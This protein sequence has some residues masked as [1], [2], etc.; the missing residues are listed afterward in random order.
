MFSVIIKTE[1]GTR[2]NHYVRMHPGPGMAAS[3][4]GK[5]DDENAGLV[6]GRTC[7]YGRDD[8][9][10]IPACPVRPDDCLIP[11]VPDFGGKNRTGEEA[12]YSQKTRGTDHEE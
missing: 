7:Q 5:S 6:Q 12:A 11:A 10:I 8:R 3:C 1:I 2:M 4:H 9:G